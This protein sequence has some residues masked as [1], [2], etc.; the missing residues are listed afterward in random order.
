MKQIFLNTWI[1]SLPTVK[2][3]EELNKFQ[4]RCTSIK[5]GFFVDLAEKCPTTPTPPNDTPMFW[6]FL[7]GNSSK[8]SEIWKA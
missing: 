3:W 5:S 1:C 7:N 2:I 8:F 6:Q 4:A